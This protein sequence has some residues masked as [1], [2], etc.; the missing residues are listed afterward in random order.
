MFKHYALILALV[1]STASIA[2]SDI[3]PTTFLQIGEPDRMNQDYVDNVF[4]DS[5][6]LFFKPSGGAF[7]HIDKGIDYV[8]C[9]FCDRATN[10]L[11]LFHFNKIDKDRYPIR[12]SFYGK[13]PP[14]NYYSDTIMFIDSV[15]PPDYFVPHHPGLDS[16]EYFYHP[17]DV[18]VSC[19][20]R[21]YNP[22]SDFVYVLDQGNHRIVKLRFDLDKD[23][24]IW[25]SAFGSDTL[26]FPTAIDYMD[27]GTPSRADDDILVADGRLCK[28][29]RYSASGDYETWYGGYGHGLPDIGYPTGVAVSSDSDASNFFYISDSRNGCVLSY[30]SDPNADIIYMGRLYLPTDPI[31]YLSALDT[32]KKGNIYV[33]DL[34][35]Q[36]IWIL[37]PY[38]AKIFDH[39]GGPGFAPGQFNVPSDIYIDIQ[40][41]QDEMVVCELWDALSGIQSFVLDRNFGKKAPAS[42]G[43]P[44]RF[45]LYSNYPNPFNAAT[46]IAF[47]LPE[48]ANVKIDIYNILGQRVMRLVDKPY[49][50]GH[51]Q[52]IWHA[53]QA[54]SGIYFTRI[55]AGDK[56]AVK[57]MLLLK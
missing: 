24:L 11:T 15:T 22:D 9:I 14:I 55:V 20:G 44:T 45:A 56:I 13:Q 1:V 4:G 12:M 43:L 5:V 30:Y 2:F 6:T 46:A 49:P 35:N 16:A 48:P 50:A 34:F 17:I 25:V 18:A 33:V 31:P 51:H 32:D 8:I 28:V 38:V 52:A 42:S 54:T 29:F 39:Y 21:Y 3:T 10:G 41:E 26:L 37:E 53:N 27:Y 57:K 19:N 7:I 47:D 23:S 40:E 36:R